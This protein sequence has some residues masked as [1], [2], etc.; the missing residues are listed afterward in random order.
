MLV[1]TTEHCAL[2]ERSVFCDSK[3]RTNLPSLVALT[4]IFP[5]SQKSPPTPLFHVPTSA[6]LLDALSKSSTAHW[7]LVSLMQ[8]FVSSQA[9]TISPVERLKR[10]RVVPVSFVFIFAFSGPPLVVVV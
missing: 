10:S 1:R 2:P 7:V 9:H 6:T 5:S 3:L 4:L 8:L